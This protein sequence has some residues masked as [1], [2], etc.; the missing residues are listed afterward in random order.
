MAVDR[1]EEM[2]KVFVVLIIFTA[3]IGVIERD[4]VFQEGNPI[5]VVV[6]I[7]RISL[8]GE[9]MV[10]ISADPEK[11]IV[12]VKGGYAPYINFMETKGWKYIEQ[13][14]AGLVFEKNG[15]KHI[16]VSRKLTRF[17]MIIK[18]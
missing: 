8:P 16:S 3:L 18:H 1:G 9:S 12:K 6:G 4:A 7:L 2:K 11:Y 17:Y 10:K 13:M 5:P 15:Q 14:G